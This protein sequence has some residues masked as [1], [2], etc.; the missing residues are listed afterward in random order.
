MPEPLGTLFA[1]PPALFAGAVP[2]GE[3]PAPA[4]DG[5]GEGKAAASDSSAPQDSAQSSVPAEG[6]ATCLMCGVGAPCPGLMGTPFLQ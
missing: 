1:L 2:L 6:G 4:A 3:V 5:V